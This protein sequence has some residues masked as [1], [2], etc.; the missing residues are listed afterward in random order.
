MIVNAVFKDQNKH[1]SN[2]N[3]KQFFFSCTVNALEYKYCLINDKH[4][5]GHKSVFVEEYLKLYFICSLI[6]H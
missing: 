6:L 1:V 2:F 3:T 5:I 4:N